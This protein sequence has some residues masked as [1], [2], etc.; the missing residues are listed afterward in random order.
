VENCDLSLIFLANFDRY[1]IISHP[2]QTTQAAR[3]IVR[4]LAGKNLNFTS[5]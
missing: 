4:L 5:S 2:G 3:A 1:F